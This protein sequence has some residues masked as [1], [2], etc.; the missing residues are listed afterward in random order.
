MCGLGLLGGPCAA[1]E[2]AWAS[3]VREIARRGTC[4]AHTGPDALAVESLELGTRSVRLAASV[5]GLRGTDVTPQPMRAASL[6]FVWNGEVFADT[7]HPVP[8]ATNDGAALFARIHARAD[9]EAALVETLATVDGPYA[10]L[11]LDVRRALTQTTL[12]RVW[13]GRD[14][15]GRRSLLRAHTPEL[16]LTS[17]ASREALD[18]GFAFEEVPCASLWCTDL[19]THWPVARGAPSDVRLVVSDAPH[20]E[21]APFLDALHALL[22]ESVARRVTQIRRAPAQ[23]ADDARVAVLFSGGVD[24]T[25]LAALAHQHVPADEAIDLVNVAFENPRV[26]AA[27]APR[28]TYAVPDRLTARASAAELRALAPHRRWHLVEVDVP[29]E[30]Y[31]AHLPHI[32]ALLA[33]CTSVMDLSIAAALYF[34]A[35]AHGTVGG[36]PYVSPARVFLSGLGADELL[37]GYARHRHAFLRGGLDAL[38]AELQLDLDRLPTRNLGRDDRVVSAHA[39]EARFPFLARAVLAAV[40]A[41]PLANKADLAPG[42]EGAG[43]KRLLRTLARRL[44]LVHAAC[45]PKR[46]IQF[47]ARSA[48]LDAASARRKGSDVL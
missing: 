28:E 26:L 33:P 2:D 45:L 15:L 9:R 48:K 38:R 34:A 1:H 39:R 29:Y 5:L 23:R 35:R 36:A 3:L 31:E 16:C 46:A 32:H 10:F 37:G 27:H 8:H 25:V 44:G 17:A 41:M 13:Y 19:A 6:W 42:T 20:A 12:A 21:D 40:C 43:D 24:C 4:A 22:S 7:A 47:G 14:P 18:A 30:A 11:L